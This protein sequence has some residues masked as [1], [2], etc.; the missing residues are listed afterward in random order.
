M[1]LLQNAHRAP[2]I[3]RQCK[4]H[5]QCTDH[6]WHKQVAENSSIVVCNPRHVYFV[7]DGFGHQNSRTES[8]IISF[9]H[10]YLK[11]MNSWTDEDEAQFQVSKLL[12][13]IMY[14]VLHLREWRY[15]I[16]G[17]FKT[18]I[19]PISFTTKKSC[20]KGL[21]RYQFKATGTKRLRVNFYSLALHY[22]LISLLVEEWER[23]MFVF[24]F[25]AGKWWRC[26]HRDLIET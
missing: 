3:F 1:V 19:I 18:F 23:G 7:C 12:F 15:I 9:L 6:P 13:F 22:K 5:F 17:C 20:M 8:I 24:Q 2:C 14:L 10:L 4:V 26:Q 16:I 21:M 25:P 11:P